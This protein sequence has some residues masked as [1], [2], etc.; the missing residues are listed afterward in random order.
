MPTGGESYW[1]AFAGQNFGLFPDLVTVEYSN[2]N[3]TFPCVTFADPNVVNGPSGSV[4]DTN[5]VCRTATAEPEGTYVITVTVGG[6]QSETGLD[7]LM[8]PAVPI[9]ST[10][11]GCPT[12]RDQ[13]TYDCPT[14]GGTQISIY[15]MNLQTGLVRVIDLVIFLFCPCSHYFSVK[16]IKSG[17][18]QSQ[19]K[20]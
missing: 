17:P 13:G 5:I 14:L 12:N 9:I 4:T 16:R 18:Q 1:I 7:E 2:E 3:G 6:Q 19:A 8:F 20:P 15:G 11:E 10:I